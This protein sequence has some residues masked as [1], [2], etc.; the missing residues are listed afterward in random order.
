MHMMEHGHVDI[1]GHRPAAPRGIL[2]AASKSAADRPLPGEGMK[3]GTSLSPEDIRR[4]VA[5]MVG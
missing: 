5:D 3:T 1:R 4:I 2:S